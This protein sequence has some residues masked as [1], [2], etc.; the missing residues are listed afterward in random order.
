[1]NP[2]PPSPST[3]SPGNTLAPPSPSLTSSVTGT[4]ILTV[5]Q[6]FTRS[7]ATTDSNFPSISTSAAD[8]STSDTVVS[9]MDETIPAT[10]STAVGATGSN[11]PTS[12]SSSLTAISPLTI[13]AAASHN[14][15]KTAR[16]VA[17]V[18]V[19]L[20]VIALGIAAFIIYKRRRRARTIDGSGSGRTRRSQ[21]PCARLAPPRP[22]P[23]LPRG[24][25]RGVT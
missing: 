9:S 15:D 16:I 5:T 7:D 21:T 8:S 24:R 14:T 3:P 10:S 25:Q 22:S 18:L 2:G 13:A 6:S 19:P 23:S 12:P 4:T 17:G 20:V 11:P 1:M